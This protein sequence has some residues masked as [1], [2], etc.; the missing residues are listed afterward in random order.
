MFRVRATRSSGLRKG[1]FSIT[2]LQF[3]TVAFG[4]QTDRN[5]G[6]QMMKTNMLVSSK[7]GVIRTTALP[8]MWLLL[9]LPVGAV[10][11]LPHPRVCSEFFHLDAVFTGTVISAR[12]SPGGQASPEGWFYRLKMT[13]S[14]RGSSEGV[15][16]IFTGNDSG[17]FP[18]EKGQA[19]LVFAHKEKGILNINNCGNSAELSKAGETI[20][21]IESLLANTKSAS[22]G[23][24]G[25]RVVVSQKDASARGIAVTAKGGGKTYM[26][27]TDYDGW[28]HIHVPPGKYVVWPETSQWIVTPYDL[29][30]DNEDHVSIELGSCAELQF[31]ASPK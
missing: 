2:G 4:F 6:E 15:I 29:S 14:Y 25:G 1:P 26:G 28:F 24:I 30:Y 18:L 19:Y 7:F 11:R 10:C 9:A 12:E 17:R 13:K 21:E 31:L 3:D 22:G 23:D 16:E 8:A 27:V 5:E 20:R